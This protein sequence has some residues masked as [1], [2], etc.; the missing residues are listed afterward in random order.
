MLYN[1]GLVVTKV[2][3]KSE[4]VSW[5]TKHGESEKVLKVQVD[6]NG[7]N[8]GKQKP[9]NDKKSTFIFM[10]RGFVPSMRF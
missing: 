10:N 6:E 4:Y 8:V 2:S 7:F 9:W 5:N 1:Y 3:A